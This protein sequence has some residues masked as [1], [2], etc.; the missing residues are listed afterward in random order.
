MSIRSTGDGSRTLYSERYGQTFHSLHGAVSESRHVFVAGSGLAGRLA[1]GS[2]S[3]VLE[4]G[5]GTGLNCWLTADAALAGAAELELI[6]LEQA[7]LPAAVLRGLEFG[8]VLQQP[9]LLEE[10]LKFRESLP[11]ILPAGRFSVELGPQV[12]LTLLVGE[13][14]S[15]E[16]PTDRKSTR[17]NSS[18]VAISY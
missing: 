17:L 9:Q 11:E 4:V 10:Y 6:S 13:A 2:A 15:Q 18:H 7:V 12:Q 3:R 5:F 1:A 8:S 14:T 16:L